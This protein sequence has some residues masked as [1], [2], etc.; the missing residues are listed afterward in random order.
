M[1][2]IIA[3]ANSSKRPYLN[4]KP[5]TIKPI[6]HPKIIRFKREI[7]NTNLVQRGE[8]QKNNLQKNS[9]SNSYQSSYKAYE[10]Q[11]NHL[12]IL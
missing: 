7:L 11:S 9:R 5:D 4:T 1:I 8:S 6:D 2:K 3:Q 10:Y 12:N